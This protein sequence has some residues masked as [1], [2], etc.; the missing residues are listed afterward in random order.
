VPWLEKLGCNSKA[1]SHLRK[2]VALRLIGGTRLSTGGGFC[3]RGCAGRLSKRPVACSVL[4]TVPGDSIA[5]LRLVV[6][7]AAS[8]E[9]PKGGGCWLEAVKKGKR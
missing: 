3:L 6:G 7:C 4:R 2:S 1:L 8:A 9:R 5:E